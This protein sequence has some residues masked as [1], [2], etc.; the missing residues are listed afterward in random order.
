LRQAVQTA[1]L[2]RHKGKKNSQWSA[3]S[4]WWW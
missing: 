2:M 4:W 1:F 3:A